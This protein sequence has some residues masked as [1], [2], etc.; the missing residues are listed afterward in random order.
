MRY[1]EFDMVRSMVEKSKYT[2]E[3]KGSMTE[4]AKNIRLLKYKDN[5][6]SKYLIEL[7]DTLQVLNNYMKANTK[8]KHNQLSQNI[9]SRREADINSYEKSTYL[10]EWMQVALIF[11]RFF[12]FIFLGLMPLTLLVF[13]RSNLYEYINYTTQKAYIPNLEC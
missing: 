7:F 4:T 13:F 9:L 8:N 12:F 10:Q 5:K 3:K 2:S 1:N 11:D 6:T